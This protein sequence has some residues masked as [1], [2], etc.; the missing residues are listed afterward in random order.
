MNI[1]FGSDHR[2]FKLKGKLISWALSKDLKEHLSWLKG[3]SKN[4]AELVFKNNRGKPFDVY[5]VRRTVKSIGKKIGRP[6]FTTH[7]LR[8]TFIT[9]TFNAKANLLDVQRIVGHSSAAT[10]SCYDSGD[11]DRKKSVVD[12][13]PPIELRRF[14][15]VG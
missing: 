7:V 11:F 2:G 14:H 12:N 4:S 10:T 13:L 6:D 5:N 8:N 1:Y 15:I 9:L 3:G